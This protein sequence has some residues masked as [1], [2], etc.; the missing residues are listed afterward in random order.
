MLLL[1]SVC[2]CC[3]HRRQQHAH[4]SLLSALLSLS[5]CSLTGD[6]QLKRVV[7]NKFQ[8]T[9]NYCYK[10]FAKG[11]CA[12]S[13]SLSSSSSSSSSAWAKFEGVC[14]Q[15]TDSIF[16]RFLFVFWGQVTGQ[17][18]R[19]SFEIELAIEREM[20]REMQ[21]EERRT[22]AVWETINRSDL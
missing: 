4:F 18:D 16:F 15:T 17:S 20:G 6:E 1:L 7:D 22:V 10:Y 8:T 12:R 21:R 2:C 9:I 14:R 3:R 13:S 11:F 19:D 5:E